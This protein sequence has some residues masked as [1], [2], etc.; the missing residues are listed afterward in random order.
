MHTDTCIQTCI[1]MHVNTHTLTHSHSRGS[2][3]AGVQ[4]MCLCG[5]ASSQ[6]SV[7]GGRASTLGPWETGWHRTSEGWWARKP[8][9]AY[10]SVQVPEGESGSQCGV[11]CSPPLC[12]LVQPS[13]DWTRPTHTGESSLFS[14][15]PSQM[16]LS[17]VNALPDSPR[18]ML[19]QLSGHPVAQSH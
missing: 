4:G 10:V 19:Y 5:N 7:C 13:T 12:L 11:R 6:V 2:M 8:G 17:S 9:R 14:P 18:S 16:L 1:H 15:A 3:S